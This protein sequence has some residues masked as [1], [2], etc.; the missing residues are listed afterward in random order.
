MALIMENIKIFW[1]QKFSE[2]SDYYYGTEANAF[3]QEACAENLFC[4]PNLPKTALLLGDGEGRNGVWLAEKGF[5]VTTIDISEFAINKSKALAQS[6]NCKL[7]WI[8][9]DVCDAT[10]WPKETFSV[11]I[12]IYLHLPEKMQIVLHNLIKE[13]LCGSGL[14]IFEV[15]SKRQIEYQQK[16]ESGGP[17]NSDFLY[18]LERLQRDFSSYKILYLSEKE[19]FLQE[20]IGHQGIA[21]VIRMIAQKPEDSNV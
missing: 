4:N 15:F 16:H 1:D 3:L 18:S 9:G 5:D 13:H 19:T 20:G 12:V 7:R 21:S 14:A 2:T 17:R 8:Q 6:R 11:I 10:I